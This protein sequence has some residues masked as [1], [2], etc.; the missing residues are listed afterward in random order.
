MLKDDKQIHWSLWWYPIGGL[1][2]EVVV[3]NGQC[4]EDS[5]K[6]K[7]QVPG[8]QALAFPQVS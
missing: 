6:T 3:W 7:D 1:T 5:D 8:K 2:E 4:G